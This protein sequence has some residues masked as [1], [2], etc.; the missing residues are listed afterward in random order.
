MSNYIFEAWKVVEDEILDAQDNTIAT[1]CQSNEWNT[2]AGVVIIG[3]Q[4]QAN[5]KLIAAAPE[6]LRL[7]Q[8]LTS[9]HMAETVYRME[10]FIDVAE[11]MKKLNSDD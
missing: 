8:R 10:A 3:M 11:L 4:W 5:A 6:M 1:L 9:S 7:I 2:T